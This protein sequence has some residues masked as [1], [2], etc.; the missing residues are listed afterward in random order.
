[1]LLK[2][3]DL[4][5]AYDRSFVLNS[6]TF[7]VKPGQRVGIV[8]PNGSGK[9]TLLQLIA[10]LI[11]PTS[12]D[13]FLADKQ[14]KS[15]TRKTIARRMALVPQETHLAFDYSVL[16]I[17][18]MGRYPHLGALALEGPDDLA[19]AYQALRKTGMEG[20]AGRQFSSLSGGEKQ[21]VII[22]SALAQ[23]T[24]IENSKKSSEHFILLLDEPTASLDFGYQLKFSAMLKSLNTRLGI[25]T[26]M[27]THDLNLAAAVCDQ[28]VLLKSGHVVSIGQTEVVLSAANIRN[29]FDIEVDIQRHPANGNLTIV[30]SQCIDEF[31]PFLV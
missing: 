17:A 8:G 9:T 2:I 30:P 6:V 5:F 10:G 14:L 20:L 13:I 1:M 3:N 4:S 22:A 19:I 27:S 24:A 16:E 31:E 12:G 29:L 18:L 11:T 7:E 21:R 26:I 15:E 28:L 23:L 25:T